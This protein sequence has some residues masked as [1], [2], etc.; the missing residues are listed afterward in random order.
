MTDRAVRRCFVAGH[1]GLVGSAIVRGLVAH[2]Y[3]EP[4]VRTR[5]ELDLRDQRE[6]ARFFREELPDVVFLAAARVG[7]IQANDTYRWDFLYENLVIQTNVLGS[8]LDNGVDR[9]VFF[10]SSCIYPRLAQQPIK[11][12]YLLTALIRKFHDAKEARAEGLDASV[13]LWGRG[14]ARREF[15]HVDDAT[16]AAIMMMES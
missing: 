8:A 16:N 13:A 14:T 4:I 10:G 2:G 15:L 7:G 1:R 11:E 6:G 5:D 12:E 3:A 9:V